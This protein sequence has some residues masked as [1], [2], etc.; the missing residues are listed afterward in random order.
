MMASSTH[1]PTLGGRAA[2]A[3]AAAHAANKASGLQHMQQPQVYN[4]GDG[5]VHPSAPTM[6]PTIK[7]TQALPCSLACCC[8]PTPPGSS[9]VPVQAGSKGGV[10]VC[11]CACDGTMNKAGMSACQFTITVNWLPRSL[12]LKVLPSAALSYFTYDTVKQLLGAEA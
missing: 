8:S 6:T 11:W 10:R 1:H 12:Q 2:A 4:Q 3:A 7:T 5:E 9:S